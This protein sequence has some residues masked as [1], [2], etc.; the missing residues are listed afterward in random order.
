MTQSSYPTMSED[1]KFFW[2]SFTRVHEEYIENLQEPCKKTVKKF[3][4]KIVLDAGLDPNNFRLVWKLPDIE[5]H[6]SPT[7]AK[8]VEP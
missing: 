6:L 7:T 4:D 5:Y 3:L 2:E 8:E 1:L